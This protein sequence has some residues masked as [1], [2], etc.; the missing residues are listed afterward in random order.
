MITNSPRNI[1]NFQRSRRITS[2]EKLIEYIRAKLGEP[3][4]EVEVTQDQIGY[5]IDSVIHKFSDFAHAAQQNV[6]F[7]IPSDPEISEYILDDRVQA[8]LGCSL[9][10]TLGQ[11]PGQGNNA[12]GISL[13]A[14][15][16][17][18]IGYVPHI[19]LQG[20]VSSL[21]TG[22]SAVSGN[23]NGVA[24]GVSSAR[25]SHGLSRMADTFVMQAHRE[26]MQTLYD[27]AVNYSFNAGTKTLKLFEKIAGNILIDANIEYIPNRDYDEIYNET[28]IKEMCVSLT[29]KQWGSNVGKYDAPLIGGAN[30]NY[31]DMKSEAE[32]EIETLDQQL[33]DRYAPALGIFSG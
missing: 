16:T 8:I 26:S 12:N 23:A 15:G 32:Q 3:V 33:L 31:A 4:I 21:E 10:G 1:D 18:G 24:G 13:G 6:G 29:K 22:G 14:F 17:I 7:I 11:V 2:E 25:N 19:T 28:W 30:I 9:G 20:E 5:I 27:R